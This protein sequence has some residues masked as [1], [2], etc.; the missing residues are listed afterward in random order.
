M[1]NP[2]SS[3]NMG[4]K[5]TH[6]I[7]NFSNIGPTCRGVGGLVGGLTVVFLPTRSRMRS[8]SETQTC[9]EGSDK[10]SRLR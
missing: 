9:Q 3:G 4:N 6:C 1:I 10:G 5:S 2:S 8:K 7:L